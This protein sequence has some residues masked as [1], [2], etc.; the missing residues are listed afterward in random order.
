MET[1]L[2][3]LR[4]WFGKG[5]KGDWVRVGTDGEIKG[6]CARE[7]G[8]GKPKCMPR[9]KAHSMSKKDRASSARRKRRA[10]PNPDRPGTGNKP[11]MV[12]TDKKESVDMNEKASHDEIMKDINDFLRNNDGSGVAGMSRRLEK[13]Y[14]IGPARARSMIKTALQKVKALPKTGPKRMGRFPHMKESVNEESRLNFG[15]KVKTP[16]GTVEIRKRDTRGMRGKQ[17]AYA[18]VLH[19][20][21]GKKAS[22]GSHPAPTAS[23]VTNMAK[24]FK[25]GVPSYMAHLKVES[26]DLEEKL[27]VGDKVKFKKGIDP[28]TARSYGDAIRKSGKVVKDY[29]DGDV[30][31]NFGGNNDKSVDAKLLV[32]ESVELEEKDV[33]V[34]LELL[35]L[36]NKGMALPAGSIEH[37]KVMKQIDDMRKKLGMK[38][39]VEE[40][41]QMKDP[42]KDVM[43]VKNKKVIVIDKGKEKEYLKKGWQLAEE[44]LDEKNVPTNPALWAKMKAQAKAKFDVYPSA[45]A[46]GWAAKKYKAAGGGWKT[47]SVKEMKSFWDIRESVELDEN[48]TKAHLRAKSKLLGGASMMDLERAGNNIRAYAKKSG[49]MDK[50]DFDTAADYV[51]A[52]GRLADANK[53]GKVLQDLSTHVGL[54]DT[55]VR[56]K[57]KTMLPTGLKKKV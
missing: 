27:K 29:G 4:K 39:S 44:D 19:M 34:P 5:K 13:K 32:K 56:D 51:I 22:M 20:K 28:K 23:A 45:Y 31:V 6:D 55:D 47:E 16:Q 40:A 48:Q 41:R 21:N 8:E 50:K 43:V 46:N 18:L 3:D 52:L 42:K 12:K 30:K 10:D 38:E 24:R 1:K 11:I 37:K 14:G 15:D 35:K 49:G 33:K 26:V 57:I 36:Y 7:P 2:E 25:D 54:L 53:V 9:S 17:D